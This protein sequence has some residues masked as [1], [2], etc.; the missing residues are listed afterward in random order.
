MRT[1]KIEGPPEMVAEWSLK[2]M[3]SCSLAIGQV[4]PEKPQI[5]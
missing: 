5:A 2:V 4:A 3:T 1:W